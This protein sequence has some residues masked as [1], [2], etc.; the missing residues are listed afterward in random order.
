MIT[1]SLK[2]EQK[3]VFIVNLQFSQEYYV[4]HN[5]PLSESEMED[6]HRL[7]ECMLTA[8]HRP[9]SFI[10]FCF[11]F[12]LFIE[13]CLLVFHMKSLDSSILHVWAALIHFICSQCV[14]SLFWWSWIIAGQGEQTTKKK[15]NMKRKCMTTALGS[16]RTA[17]WGPFLCACERHKERTI[18]LR[19]KMRLGNWIEHFRSPK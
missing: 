18:S 19:A 2:K 11:F 3:Q 5:M 16:R 14:F 1:C 10:Y 6:D 4:P 7:Q 13:K 9:I 17:H 8:I 15:I 12:Y